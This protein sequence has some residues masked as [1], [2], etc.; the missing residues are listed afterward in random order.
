MQKSKFRS[1]RS[2]LIFLLALSAGIA[3][4]I[5]SVAI[6]LN[7]TNELKTM[8]KTSLLNTADILAKNLTAPIEFDD[9]DSA[10]M[11]LD[12][13]EVDSSIEGAFITDAENKLFA[14]FISKNTNLKSAKTKLDNLYK[15]NKPQKNIAFIDSDNIIISVP[16]L[17]EDNYVA[18]FSIVATTDRLNEMVENQLLM[19]LMV[20]I[21]SL[22]IIVIIAMKLQKIFT[23]PIFALRD[24]MREVTKN[25]NYQV[26][27]DKKNNDEFGELFRG[28][29]TMIDT[30]YEQSEIVQ[31]AK[32]EV[33]DIHKHTRESIE[34]AA[35]I[36]SSLIP[37]NNIFRKYFQEFFVI[38]HPKDTVGGDIYLVNE[39]RDNN[40]LLIL[41]VDCTGHGVPGAFVT[42]LV[43]AVEAQL[44]AEIFNN[45][46]MEISTAWVMGFFNNKLKKLL[47]QD[48]PDSVSNVGW[49]GS[50]LYYNKKDMIMKFSGA[51]SPMFYRKPDGEI[52]TLKGTRKSVGYK[53]CPYDFKYKEITFEVE[54]GTKVYLTTDGYLDQNGGDKDFPFGK[55][56]FLKIIEDYGV[57]TMADQQEMFM[58]EMAEYEEMIPNN[59]RNDDMTVIGFTV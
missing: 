4:S 13:L 34:Y 53:Q 40:E 5:S 30:I 46:D 18:S 12:T 29:N 58:Y 16:I 32:K 57:E 8:S 1:I 6:F 28:F 31:K 15:T 56:K 52:V 14:S 42:M 45:P 23:E 43:K 25:S 3:L 26:H 9:P 37:E 19:L 49:D 22:V 47:K 17:I 24:S 35:I 44:M 2:K 36:Q 51:E 39:L 20:S 27:V 55:K 33:E 54:K 50:V 41:C 11:L 10:K 21:I 7:T 38:W 48:T 59:D